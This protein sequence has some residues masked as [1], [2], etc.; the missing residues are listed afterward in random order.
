LPDTRACGPKTGPPARAAQAGGKKPACAEAR[1]R[2]LIAL[3]STGSW[4]RKTKMRSSLA[5]CRPHT[6]EG[7]SIAPP[8]RAA[9][10]VV[11]KKQHATRRSCHRRRQH[12]SAAVT[13]PAPIRAAKQLAQSRRWLRS[14]KL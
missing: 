1:P 12:A 11:R 5:S 2:V 7:P 8:A 4:A 14:P 3:A 9:S 6:R 10:G 13:V